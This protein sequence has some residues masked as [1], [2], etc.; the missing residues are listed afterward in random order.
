MAEY[1]YNLQLMP[2][3]AMHPIH[4]KPYTVLHCNLKQFKRELD[5]HLLLDV[6]IEG[7]MFLNGPSLP[8]LCPRKMELR[9]SSAI[10]I[11]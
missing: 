4:C 1:V 5:T 3:G 7:P 9:A 11:S 8:L 6:V 2:A 10:S